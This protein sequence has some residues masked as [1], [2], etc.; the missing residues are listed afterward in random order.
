MISVNG[1]RYAHSHCVQCLDGV[2]AHNTVAK[3]NNK[4]ISV[5]HRPRS[6]VG[7]ILFVA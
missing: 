2:D 6:M 4:D 7:R 5:V 3:E 1:S